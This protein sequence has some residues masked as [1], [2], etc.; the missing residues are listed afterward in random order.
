M[1]KTSPQRT[2]NKTNDMYR[3]LWDYHTEGFKFED[4]EFVDI[5]A[6]VKYAISQGYSN[7]FFIVKVIDWEAKEVL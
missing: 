1:K 2:L 5:S 3:I 6:A 7:P 4:G